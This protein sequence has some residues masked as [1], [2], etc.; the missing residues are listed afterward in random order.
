M[1]LEKFTQIVVDGMKLYKR[2]SVVPAATVRRHCGL[3]VVPDRGQFA[4]IEAVDDE[5]GR[6]FA[7]VSGEQCDGFARI[8]PGSRLFLI[9][10]FVNRTKFPVLRVSSYK[11]LPDDTQENEAA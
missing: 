8:R 6:F 4:T 11:L 1:V 10:T 9:G 2:E 7:T 5:L 3:K